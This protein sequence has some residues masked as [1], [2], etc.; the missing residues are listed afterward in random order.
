[1]AFKNLM[2]RGEGDG[3]RSVENTPESTVTACRTVALPSSCIDASSEF[4]GTI[5]SPVSIRIDGRVKGEVHGGEKIIV[6]EPATVHAR[7]EAA[8]VIIAGEVKG[9]IAA[10]SKITL[11]KTARVTGDL[12]TPGIVIEEGAKLEG[13]IV[14]APN[15]QLADPKEPA[16]RSAAKP[17]ESAAAPASPGATPPT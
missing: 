10:T 8:S 13:R 14:I 12:R 2:A 1:M 11:Q 5:R 17:R 3:E 7:I 15:E 6:G 9:D 4:S 16:A